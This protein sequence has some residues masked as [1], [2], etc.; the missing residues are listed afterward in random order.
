MKLPNF[1]IA[2]VWLV[3]VGMV[4]FGCQQSP[5]SQTSDSFSYTFK[6]VPEPASLDAVFEGKRFLFV[7]R[8]RGYWTPYYQNWQIIPMAQGTFFVYPNQNAIGR[9]S[10]IPLKTEADF[11]TLWR[12]LTNVLR[13]VSRKQPLV[14]DTAMF[15]HVYTEDAAFPKEWFPQNTPSLCR[16]CVIELLLL[17][18]KQWAKVMM[19]VYSPSQRALRAQ[20]LDML[21]SFHVLPPQEKVAF[22]IKGIPANFPAFYAVVPE[23]FI[24]KGY[25]FNMGSLQEVSWMLKKEDNSDVFLR[26]D[27]FHGG[28]SGV[29]NYSAGAL[30]LNGKMLPATPFPTTEKQ[31]LQMVVA[32]LAPDWKIEKT[33]YSVSG[34]NQKR[35]EI[36]AKLRKGDLLR[37]VY[38][39]GVSLMNA[40]QDWFMGTT[41]S[42]S[43][44]I[45]V[46]T[47]QVPNTSEGRAWAHLLL[48]ALMDSYFNPQW[49]KVV[50]SR[51]RQFQQWMDAW[52]QQRIQQIKAEG[53]MFRQYLNAQQQT[54]QL[55]SEAIEAH[56]AFTADMNEAWANI[57]GEKLYAQDPSTGEVFYLDDVGG[58]YLRD[59]ESGTIIGG[60]S[61]YNAATLQQ[62]GWQPLTT[63]YVPFK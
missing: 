3:L 23:G 17:K 60:V 18:G 44:Y 41:Y 10:F 35:Y 58:N 11:D 43:L 59:P 2:M 29:A 25:T 15:V 46:H 19:A 1:A 55:Y 37:W 12:S 30:Y 63:A 16:Q 38:I 40:F 45:S 36:K 61:D 20:L 50:R 8:I 13:Q 26:R 34:T 57:L 6:G 14:R 47:L 28:V 54:Q 48:S 5:S 22:S 52:T 49:I 39:T 21:S 33:W 31:L 7:N 24:A 56:Q 51:N 4:F 53:A 9:L 27:V 32:S 42:A 62:Q